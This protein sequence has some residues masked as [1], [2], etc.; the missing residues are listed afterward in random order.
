MG[1]LEE[2]VYPSADAEMRL[3]LLVDAFGRKGLLGRT[4]L[5]KTDFFVRYPGYLR[6]ALELREVHVP[7]PFASA[8]E[9][10][11][12][13]FRYGPWDPKYFSLLGRLRSRNLIE[14]VPGRGVGFRTTNKGATLAAHMR[15]L[16]ELREVSTRTLL[17]AEHLG[18]SGDWLRKFIYKH[19]PEVVARR[20]GAAISDAP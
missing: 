15:V 18:Q 11:M 12:I 16:P 8:T 17:V 13:R 6:R 19:F 9:E 10:P 4:Q 3:L 7:E 20:W 2:R 1:R 14:W 5:A